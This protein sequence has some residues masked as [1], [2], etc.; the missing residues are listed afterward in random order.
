MSH[1]LNMRRDDDYLESFCGVFSLSHMAFEVWRRHLIWSGVSD[2][3]R[4]CPLVAAAF[5]SMF[6]EGTLCDDMS[7]LQRASQVRQ[8]CLP[9]LQI[10]P[11]MDWLNERLVVSLRTRT[12]SYRRTSVGGRVHFGPCHGHACRSSGATA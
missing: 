4:A 10:T 11:I 5:G 12:L 7:M 8:D 1:L 2:V 9:K 6:D 3:I